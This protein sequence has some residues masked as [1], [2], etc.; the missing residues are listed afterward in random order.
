M[1]LDNQVAVITGAS[2][3]L[4]AAVARRLAQAGCRLALVARNGDELGGLADSLKTEFAV[5]V[6]CYPADL[7]KTEAV[8][9][10]CGQILAEFGQVDILVNNAGIGFYKPF[11]EHSNE[12]ID[13]I[14][15][16]NI[17]GAFHMCHAL[18]PVMTGRGYGQIINIASDLSDRPLANMATYAA[19]KYALRGFSLSLMREVKSQGVKVTLVNPG[20]INT[21]FGNGTPD[22]RHP[23]DAMQPAGIA[24]TL[25]QVLSQPQ[26]QIIDEL[27]LHPTDQDY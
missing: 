20:I 17:K 25:V 10:T 8:Y 18:V 22:D 12:E 5:D 9:Q 19:S 13:A 6:R 1:S 26:Y 21:Y 2:R 27:T 11:A 24:D 16:L 7:G 23:K 4:G 3:G 14:I 15:D